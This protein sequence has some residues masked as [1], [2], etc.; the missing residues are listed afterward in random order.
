VVDRPIL[1]SA[2]MIQALLAGRETQTRR[3]LNPQPTLGAPTRFH[4][5]GTCN[6]TF[7]SE[8]EAHD[9]SGPVNAF[10][11]PPFVECHTTTYSIGDRLWVREAF[12]YREAIYSSRDLLPCGSP[13]PWY[14]ADGN[15]ADGDCSRPKPSIHMPRWASRLTLTVTDV[16]VQRGMSIAEGVVNDGSIFEIPGCY[17]FGPDPVTAYFGLWEE[18]NGKGSW[19]ANPFVAAYSF[20]VYRENIDA[21]PARD[22]ALA[23]V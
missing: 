19:H 18:I 14:W 13:R 3:A 20:T 10:H 17:H 11:K 12:S 21:M 8:W 16:R 23:E 1:F 7:R 5:I 4:L 15:V 9:A 6:R 22:A 2:P